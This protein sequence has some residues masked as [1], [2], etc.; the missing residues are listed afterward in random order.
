[1]SYKYTTDYKRKYR[2]DSFDFTVPEFV[3]LLRQKAEAWVIEE[4]AE[5]KIRVREMLDPAQNNKKDIKENE[6][7]IKEHPEYYD[8]VTIKDY[9]RF[10]SYDCRYQIFIDPADGSFNIT[11]KTE[12]GYMDK[13]HKG[14]KKKQE[15]GTLC[16]H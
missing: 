2:F 16:C 6:E 13:L 7:Y 11:M 8:E 3:E 9:K 15:K 4:N 12:M 1:M 14:L 10:A 5:R